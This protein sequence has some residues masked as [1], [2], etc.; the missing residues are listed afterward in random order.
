MGMCSVSQPGPCWGALPEA[1]GWGRPAGGG[2]RGSALRGA[3]GWGGA[4]R[5]D[6]VPW[7]V[8]FPFW[9]LGLNVPGQRGQKLRIN[10]GTAAGAPLMNPPNTMAAAGPL[11]GGS[12]RGVGGAL[13]A[14][15]RPCP[16]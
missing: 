7:G 16:L 15:P 9:V 1:L 14:P 10:P 13:W 12:P 3:P 8:L 5:G 6:S 4:A 2:L 11:G